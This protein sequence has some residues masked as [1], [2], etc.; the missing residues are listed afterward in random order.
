MTGFI[1]VCFSDWNADTFQPG[2]MAIRK[3]KR[4]DQPIRRPLR[5]D[6]VQGTDYYIKPDPDF[7][8]GLYVCCHRKLR[9]ALQ[10]GDT[11]FFRTLWC[12]E[13]YLIGY[14]LIEAKFRDKDPVCVANLEKS[15]L[16]DFQLTITPRLIRRVRPNAVLVPGRHFN[17]Q[18]NQ[19]FGR[20]YSRLSDPA[21][22]Y[23]IG[24]IKRF[25]Q[26]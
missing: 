22:R 24:R 19:V 4:T 8:N 16:I 3:G 9:E 23:L 1:T 2:V 11:L 14:F 5:P 18:V 25:N 7:Q 10:A 12:G 13:P 21:T 26:H 15:R 20:N 6:E 17:H